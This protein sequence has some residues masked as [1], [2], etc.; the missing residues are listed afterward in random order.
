MTVECVGRMMV[1][2]ANAVVRLGKDV[3]SKARQRELI[4]KVSVC[5]CVSCV[6]VWCSV[7]SVD[8]EFG[9]RLLFRS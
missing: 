1:D 4:Q 7:R 8:V 6:C 5:V 3:L 9:C 2:L